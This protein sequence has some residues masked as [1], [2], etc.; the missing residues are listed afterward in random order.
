VTVQF[1]KY[2]DILHWGFEGWLLGEDEHGSWLWVPE[3]SKRWK[4]HEAKRPPTVDAV[5]C[6]PHDGWWHLHYNGDATDLTHFVDIT[7]VPVWVSEDRYEMV[8]LDLDVIAHPDGRIEIDD[9][10]EFEVHQ[11][12]YGYTEEMIGM[13]LSETDR[14]VRA[15][16]ARQEPFFDVAEAWLA[17]ARSLR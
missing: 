9:E 8:D 3:G 1:L 13:A 2:P 4:G 11:V 16:R 5:M 6:A 14:I 15:L 12:R 7:T 10:D 17:R